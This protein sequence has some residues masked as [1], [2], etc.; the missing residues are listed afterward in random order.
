MGAMNS[1]TFDLEARHAAT[2][3][4]SRGATYNQFAYPWLYGFDFSMLPPGNSA[5]AN[6]PHL[7]SQAAKWSNGTLSRAW[8]NDNDIMAL[9]NYQQIQLP[10]GT[11]T[12]R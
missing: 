5:V 4:D 11:D 2:L 6:S 1:E 10:A 12:R 3:H 9:S 7:T 8:F